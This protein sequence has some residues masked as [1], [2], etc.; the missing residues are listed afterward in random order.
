MSFILRNILASINANGSIPAI[1]DLGFFLTNSSYTAITEDF[2]RYEALSDSTGFMPYLQASYGARTVGHS[3]G[4]IVAIQGYKDR[5]DVS[6]SENGGKD[7]VFL[8]SINNIRLVKEQLVAHQGMYYFVGRPVSTTNWF[9]YRLYRLVPEFAKGE[10]TSVS[11]FRLEYVRDMNRGSDRIFLASSETHIIVAES[12]SDSGTLRGLLCYSADQGNTWTDEELVHPYGVGGVPGPLE[13]FSVAV[14]ENNNVYVVGVPRNVDPLTPV[15]LLLISTGVIGQPRT[16]IS[17]PN[18]TNALGITDWD[19]DRPVITFTAPNTVIFYLSTFY[20]HENWPALDAAG[21]VWISEDAGT[22]W[23]RVLANSGV[24]G[25]HFS[26]DG[27]VLT[28][29]GYWDGWTGGLHALTYSTDRG[30]TWQ[31]DTSTDSIVYEAEQ[32]GHALYA[33]ERIFAP[34][35]VE[36]VEAINYHTTK[37]Q[38]AP[39]G[40]NTGQ[41]RKIASVESDKIMVLGNFSA[42][43]GISRTNIARYLSDWTIDTSFNIGSNVSISDF[44]PTDDNKYLVFGEYLTSL[45]GSAVSSGIAR[46]NNDGTRDLT[47]TIPSI[48]NSVGSQIAIT[49]MVRDDNT[50]KYYITADSLYSVN[51]VVCRGVARLNADFTHDA[52]FS[53]AIITNSARYNV[54]Y[55]FPDGRI[56]VNNSPYNGI[57]IMNPDGSF[58][59]TFPNLGNN[60]RVECVLD[61][62]GG[63]IVLFGY[64]MSVNSTLLPAVKMNATTYAIDTNWVFSTVE[65]VV[66]DAAIVNGEIIVVGSFTQL[67]AGKPKYI[68]RLDPLTG[69]P[70]ATQWDLNVNNMIFSLEA[71]AD[72][73][74][75]LGGTF[76]LV[77]DGPPPR[78]DQKVQNSIFRFD[79]TP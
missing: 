26:D 18:Y 75:V 54:K 30:L 7:F 79:I 28:L 24:E 67:G 15:N 33:A 46:I 35:G 21:D 10:A 36:T 4:R 55:I 45:G 77:G 16:V 20:D 53:S 51:E 60:A 9:P 70:L 17:G 56:L 58:D 3:D 2:S 8:Q 11:T 65:N 27:N 48:K 41:I 38:A 25:A 52:T 29:A 19:F 5:V 14:N 49:S 66:L 71:R 61:L 47:L 37:I 23:T 6:Y 63:D 22:S 43:E 76:G 34:G 39:T 57:Q 69:A 74:I 40:T 72:N 44:I 59:T 13:P 32:N 50:G 73:T 42:I 64:S 68:A 12:N 31:F 62:G 78:N 1:G